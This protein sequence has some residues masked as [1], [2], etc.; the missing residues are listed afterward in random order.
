MPERLWNVPNVI[1]LYRIAAAP[2]IAACLLRGS[3]LV[4]RSPE[5]QPIDSLIAACAAWTFANLLL[6]ATP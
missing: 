6:R 4:Y 2:V 1:S 5:R 3:A